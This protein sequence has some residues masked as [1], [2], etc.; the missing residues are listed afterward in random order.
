MD[1]N[2]LGVTLVKRVLLV[3][4]VK[5]LTQYFVHCEHVYL[6]LPK[7]A[8]QILVAYYLALIIRVLQII[9]FDVFPDSF[10]G[11]RA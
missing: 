10:D 5:I 9:G 6:V 4:G 8:A 2:V 7:Y 1:K 3:D 11:L